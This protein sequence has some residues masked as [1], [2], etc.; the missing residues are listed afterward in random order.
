MADE[1][2]KVVRAYQ[3]FF[4]TVDGQV[5]LADLDT[6]FGTRTSYVKGDTHQTAFHEGQ[7]DVVALIHARRRLTRTQTQEK[8][9]V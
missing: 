4:E 7:R 5:I 8:A 9:T 1:R 6:N 3:A 2:E